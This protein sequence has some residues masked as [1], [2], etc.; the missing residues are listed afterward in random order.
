MTKLKNDL[1]LNGN[2][3]EMNNVT[4]SLES[5]IE[6]LEAYQGYIGNKVSEQVS[7]KEWKSVTELSSKG[8]KVDL[9]IKKVHGLKNE[10]INLTFDE[11]KQLDGD[12]VN[13]EE[14]SATARTSWTI[15]DGKIRIETMRIDGTPYSNVV[16]LDLFKSIVFCALKY[17]EKY[18]YVKTTNVLNDMHDEIMLNSDYKKAVR[19]P[20][21][22]TFKVLMKENLFKNDEKSTHKYLLAGSKE[23][24][25]NWVNNLK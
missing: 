25:I 14:I 21:Y 9:F 10:W 15:N 24:L 1:D 6:S 17:V 18:K 7:N 3:N 5:L 4:G 11:D 8:E 22:A 20:I 23:Q 12:G 16:P 19:I 2:H 13:R